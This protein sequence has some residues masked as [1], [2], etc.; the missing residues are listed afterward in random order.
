MT[1]ERIDLGRFGEETALSAIE[2]AGYVKVCTNYRCPLGE[3]DLIAMDGDTLV[4]IEIKTRKGRSPSEAKEAVNYKKQRQI[5][6]VAFS[7]MKARGCMGVKARF[8]VVAIG[9]GNNGPEIELIK[10]AFDAVL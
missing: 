10:N 7:Y 1:R 8:D 2:R 4:F 3:I 6:K 9:M 5:T